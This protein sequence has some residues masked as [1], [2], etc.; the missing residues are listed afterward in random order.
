MI[1]THTRN[2][3]H[4][5]LNGIVTEQD[6]HEFLKA[7]GTFTSGKHYVNVRSLGSTHWTD[8]SIG[9]CIVCVIIHG[10]VVTAMLSFASQRWDDGKYWRLT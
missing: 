5:R 2:R 1:S 4:E 7:A 10:V 9:D 8:D 3:I 6:V